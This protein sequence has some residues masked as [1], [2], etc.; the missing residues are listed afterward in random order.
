V[1][2]LCLTSPQ[3]GVSV[4]S[5]TAGSIP[6]ERAWGDREVDTKVGWLGGSDVL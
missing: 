5:E 3:A 6:V 2:R 4:L 1:D